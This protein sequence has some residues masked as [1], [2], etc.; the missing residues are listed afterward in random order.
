MKKRPGDEKLIRSKDRITSHGEV[1]MPQWIVES[2]VKQMV[3][4]VGDYTYRTEATFLDPSCGS[5]NFLVEILERK[6]GFCKTR[7]QALDAL[8][9]L[10]G[11]DIMPDNVM[12]CRSRLG[13]IMQEYGVEGRDVEE[14]LERNIIEGDAINLIDQS[15][16]LYAPDN[17]LKNKRFDVVIGNLPYQGEKYGPS[18]KAEPIYDLFVFV[19]KARSLSPKYMVFITPSRWFEKRRSLRKMLGGGH[20]R[21]IV[22]YQISSDVFYAVDYSDVFDAVDISGGVSYYFYFLWD[23]DYEGPCDFRSFRRTRISFNRPSS[24]DLAQ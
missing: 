17:F 24:R 14:I 16:G 1:F 22:D 11:I 2:I 12:E 18:R 9:S 6:L 7:H 15:K 4:L 20:I 10:Y 23:R 13:R 19:S 3:N 8:D 21:T 5:G